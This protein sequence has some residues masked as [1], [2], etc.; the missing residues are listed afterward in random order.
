MLGRV[1]AAAALIVLAAGCAGIEPAGRNSRN[2]GQ[3]VVAEAPARPA[4]QRTL[5]PPQTT[6]APQQQAAVTP[7]PARQLPP[8][9]QAAPVTPP[10]QMAAVTPPPVQVAPTPA[11]RTTTPP[12]QPEIA[13]QGV[14]APPAPRPRAPANDDIVVPGVQERQVPPP[15]GDPRSV[16]ERMQDINAWDRCVS[17]VQAAFETDPTRPQLNSPEDVCSQ[18]LGMASRTSVPDSRIRR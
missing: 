6:P 11:P 2:G 15:A 3:P 9:P 1:S 8:P 13:A 10:Q 5:P 12:P 7:P 4:P 16:A 17:R 14:S 18:S